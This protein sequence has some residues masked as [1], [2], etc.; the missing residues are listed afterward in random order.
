MIRAKT[1]ASINAWR[2]IPSQ[3]HEQHGIHVS[4]LAYGSLDMSHLYLKNDC[5]SN[6][7]KSFSVVFH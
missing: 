4:D 1:R 2:K 6:Q 3:D 7:L 5:F